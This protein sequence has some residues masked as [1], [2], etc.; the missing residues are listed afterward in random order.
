MTVTAPIVSQACILRTRL[1]DLSIRRMLKASDSV[2][3][4]GKPSGTTTTINV[5]ATIR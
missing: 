1:C 2:T 3:L 4:I 5:T